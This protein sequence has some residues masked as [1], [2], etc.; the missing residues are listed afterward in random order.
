L[1]QKILIKEPDLKEVEQR[2]AV[3]IGKE[4]KEIIGYTLLILLCTPAFIV[5]AGIVV[6]LIFAFTIYFSNW[7][8]EHFLSASAIYTY[9]NI[10]LG[11][12]IIFVLRY[13]NPPEEPHE[14]DLGWL[15]GI[16]LFIAL[17]IFTYA[18][19]FQ[20]NNP[21]FFGIVYALTG[22]IILGLNG[23][24][25]M[26]NP[27]PEEYSTLDIFRSLILSCSAFIAMSYGEIFRGSWLFFPPKPDEIR[28]GAWILC[29]LAMGNTWKLG[30]RTEQRRVLSILARLKFV[31]MT[32]NK[33]RLTPKGRD[34]VVLGIDF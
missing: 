28:L 21:V 4:R 14:F 3:I 9:L 2:L 7:E 22:L 34:F 1:S 19:D 20:Q 6:L 31:K 33:L 23:S 29:K 13:S 11:Y 30:S 26:N 8:I 12:M 27:V 5:L 32:E 24:A 16:A 25:Y 10:F 15:C 18:T 17:V